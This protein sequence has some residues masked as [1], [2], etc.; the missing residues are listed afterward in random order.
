M[1]GLQEGLRIMT[2]RIDSHHHLWQFNAAE[3]DW[4]DDRMKVLQRDYLS[5]DLEKVLHAENIDGAVAV[6]ARQSIDETEWLLAMAARCECIR[7]VVG[8]A[9]L[10]D[11]ELERAL[12]A[13]ASNPILKGFRHVIQA[14]PDENYILREDFNRG[15]SALTKAGLVFDI[16]ILERQLPQA[17][18]F[19]SRHP[20]QRFVLDHIGKPAI[21]DHRYEP[22]R[23][24]IARLAE[25]ENVS[26]KVSGMVTEASWQSWSEDDLR[27]YW[28]SVLEAFTPQRLMFG[29][30]WPVCLVASSY[31]RW[32]EVVHKWVRRLSAPEQERILGATATEV[33]QLG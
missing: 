22:W 23:T 14:E 11:S 28:D 12:D 29:S 10:A 31:S 5:A 18:E 19:V 24:N 26:C 32:L 17:I 6:Q 2:E 9:P 8:W 33:Y 21:A 3:F 16:L 7:G 27:P 25:R 13:L 20:R 4:I 30:D 1:F 15:I